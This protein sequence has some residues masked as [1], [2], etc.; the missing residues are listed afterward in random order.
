LLLSQYHVVELM[1][2]CCCCCWVS[3]AISCP[4]TSQVD[5][6]SFGRHWSAVLQLF[7]T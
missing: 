7:P 6:P 5:S 3:F 1:M 4:E 2:S